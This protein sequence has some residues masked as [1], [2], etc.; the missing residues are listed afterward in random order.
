MPDNYEHTEATRKLFKKSMEKFIKKLHTKIDS[1]VKKTGSRY[2]RSDFSHDPRVQSMD[3]LAKNANKWF[4]KLIE[5]QDAKMITRWHQIHDAGVYAKEGD[6]VNGHRLTQEMINKAKEAYKGMMDGKKPDM[7]KFRWTAK[8]GPNMSPNIPKGLKSPF[9]KSFKSAFSFKNLNKAGKSGGKWGAII[10][11]VITIPKN[12]YLV[13]RKKRNVK[14]ALGNVA[15]D[16][17]DGFITGYISSVVGYSTGVAMGIL[18]T[19]PAGWGPVLV[20][21]TVITTSAAAGYGS[22]KLVCKVWEYV[23]IR[24]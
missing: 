12:T 16:I 14:H 22:H 4:L 3:H 24:S 1:T 15:K 7:R 2:H 10:S 20:I 6:I 11:S 19:T 18:V 23:P 21:V 9:W 5:N 8:S 13:Y 17:S